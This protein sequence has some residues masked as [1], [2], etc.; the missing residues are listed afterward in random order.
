MTITLPPVLERYANAAG[1][2]S[3]ALRRELML[4]EAWVRAAVAE[5]SEQFATGQFESLTREQLRSRLA[6]RQER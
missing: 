6:Q 1:V 3:D 2:V 4:D 5:G